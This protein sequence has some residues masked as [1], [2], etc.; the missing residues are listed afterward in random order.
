MIA[1]ARVAAYDILRRIDS[2]RADLPAALAEVRDALPDERDRALATDIATGTF[3]WRAALDHLIVHYAKR[4]L[5]KLDPEV[6]N[7][8]RLSLYQLLHL[9]RVP[10]SAVVDDGVQLTKKI[11]KKSASGFVNAVLRNVSRARKTL[12]LPARPDAGASRDAQLDYLSVTLSHPRWLVARWLDRV[13]FER[14]EAWAAFNNQPAPLTLRVHTGRTTREALIDELQGANIDAQPAHWGPDAV[15]IARGSLRDDTPRD[16]YMVQDEA[17]QVVALLAGVAP[18]PLVLDT[19]ASPGGKATA[20]AATLADTP[21]AR[22]VA[23]DVRGRRMALLARTVAATGST[24]VRLV[25]ADVT[26][27]LPFRAT[28]STV[29]V[30]AP[31]SGL[32]TLRR[33]PDIRWRRDEA[34][35]ASL[36][37]AQRRMLD[38]AAA[39]VAPGGRLVYATC[40]SEPDENEVVAAAFLAAHPDFRA[41]RADAAHP[42]IDPALVDERGHLRTEPDTHGLEL[43]FGAVF[44]RSGSL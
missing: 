44:E 10:A 33:D 13:G 41:V 7:I 17:S 43:F 15:V 3:R 9:D 38:N 40:S 36:S 27:P 11:G 4:P 24:N 20:I 2:G 12:P 19:C 14:A 21:E 1:P 28:F 25:Q 18:G 5:A 35:L 22:L 31:C 16:T 42:G 30:D 34:S 23:C 26:S 29:V 37:E 32:G 39:V 8:L 6:V